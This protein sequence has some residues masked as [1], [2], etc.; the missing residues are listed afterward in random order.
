MSTGVTLSLALLLIVHFVAIVVLVAALGDGVLDIFR[1]PPGGDDDG[2]GPPPDDPVA[3]EPG[4]NGG[5]PLPDAAQAPVR[6][7]E[8]GRLGERY[9]RPARRPAHP[10]PAPG[11][12][13]PVS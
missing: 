6:L 3:P 8:P 5:L 12:T 7:R 4:G 1:S 10:E 2:G 9:E 11:R 13:R